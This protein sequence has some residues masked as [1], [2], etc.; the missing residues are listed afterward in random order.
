MALLETRGIA[1]LSFVTNLEIEGTWEITNGNY[2]QLS[3][4]YNICP[5]P[6]Q[7]KRYPENRNI[8]PKYIQDATIYENDGFYPGIWQKVWGGAGNKNSSANINVFILLNVST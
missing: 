7:L 4:I 3:G 6:E 8:N 2:T 5:K 1:P